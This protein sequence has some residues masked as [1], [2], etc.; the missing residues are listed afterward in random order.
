MTYIETDIPQ[1]GIV[2]LLFYKGSIRMMKR[3]DKKD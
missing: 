2:E 1:P 3:N